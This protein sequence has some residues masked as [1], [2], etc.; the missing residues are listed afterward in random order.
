MK[1]SRVNWHALAVDEVLNIL[2]TRLQGLDEDEVK[3]RL[4]LYGPNEL[5]REKSRS[6][7]VIFLNQFKNVLILILL[8]AT[9]LSII[10]GEV[11]DAVLIVTIVMVSAVLGTFQEYRAERAL[12][13]LR[14]LT[15]PEATVIRSGVEKRIL[16]REIVPG[17]ILVLMAGDRVPADARVFESHELKLDESSLTGEST[18]VTKIVDPLPEDTSLADRLNMVYAGTVVVYGKGK[19]IVVATGMNTEMGKIAEMVQE[20]KE[21]KTPLEKRT[22]QIGKILAYLCLSVAVVVAGIGFFVWHYDLLTMAIWAVSLAIAAVPEALPA[23]V[24]GALAIGMYAMARKNAIVRKLPAVETLGCTTI[25]CADKTGTMTKGEMTVRKIYLKKFKNELIE[26]TGAGY[27]PR[28]EFRIGGNSINPLELKEMDLLLLGCLLCNDARL[29]KIENRW[30]VRGDPTEGALK[31]LSRKAGLTDDIES[32]YPRINEVPFSSERKRMTTLHR[33]K[34]GKI[35][36]FMKGAPEVILSRC[37]TLMVDGEVVDLSE[38]DVEEILRINDDMA[39]KALRNLAF[40]YKVFNEIP[41][42]V[43]ESIERDFTFLGIVGMIDPPRPEVK[44]ALE[45]CRKAGIKVVMITGDH[46][47][48]ALAIAKELKI[49]RDGDIA[50]TGKELDSMSDEELEKIVEKVTVYARVSPKDK[51]KIVKALKKRGHVVAMTGDG[52]NDAPALKSADIGVAMGIT[53]TEVAK[54]ASDMI[55]SDDNFATIVSAVKE[56]RRIYDDIK[57]YLFYLLGCNISE[58]L[59]PLFASFMGLPLPFTALQYLW[60]NLTTDGLP[61]MALGI[62]PAEPDVMQRPPRDP[63]ESIVTKRDALLFLTFLP[64]ATT[65]AILLNFVEG[66]RV[67]PLTRARTRIFTLMIMIELLIAISFRSLKYSAFRVGIHKNK[68][69][70]LAI[71]SSLLMQLCILYVPIFHEPF[72][73]TYPTV[74][75]WVMG[76]ISALMVF[77]SVEIVKEVASRISQHKIV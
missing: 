43:D 52:V 55:L 68:F 72:K 60:I 73:V 25:I 46:K 7:L 70:I 11:L 40:A 51:M 59:I 48:T 20:V 36:A 30:V 76:V 2:K 8:I 21:E 33:S 53:G 49:F 1:V 9:G 22:D 47:L 13:A 4:T 54:E 64:L 65:I 6:K 29:E 67:E 39:S 71:I 45:L 50:L 37:S 14:K 12:E 23:V 15:A 19:A 75:D 5:R 56:G 63:R 62:D 74:Q 31:V 61:A 24:T 58:I 41:E 42:K 69:L 44:E 77:I 3:E 16:A 34:D 26:V 35:I 28:G 66:L 57:K 38:D 18:T 17:D 27:E 10:I 32:S